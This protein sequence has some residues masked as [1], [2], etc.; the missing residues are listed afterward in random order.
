MGSGPDAWREGLQE[1]PNGPIPLVLVDQFGY[2]PQDPKFAVVRDPRTG[3]DVAVD[4][5]PGATYALVNAQTGASVKQGPLVPWNGGAVD[6]K[7]GD[8]LWTFDFSDVTTPGSYYV[9]DVER[10]KRS[11]GFEIAADVYRKLF[12]HVLRTFFYQRAGF[13]K[14]A[15]AAGADWADEASHLKAGQDAET[16]SWLDKTDASK[17]KDLHGGWYDA[18]DYNKYTS[19]HARYV[20][21]LLRTF[22]RYPKAF[23]DDFGIPESGNGT[24]DL[25]D[26]VKFGLDWLVR[27]QNQDGSVLCIQGL[28]DASPPSKATGPSYYGPATTS[29]TLASA[30]AFAY[31]ARIFAARTEPGFKELAAD[32]LA[33]AVKAWQFASENPAAIYYNNDETKQSGSQGLGA[34][35][36]EIEEPARLGW[37]VEA[38][39]YLFER[40]GEAVYRDFFD[41]NYLTTVPN[42]G[43]SHWEV[44]RHEAA[45]DYA[46]QSAAT[47]AVASAIL[48]QFTAQLNAPDGLARAALDNRDGY[49]SPVSEYTWGSNNSKAAVGRLLLLAS[50]YGVQ[51]ATAATTR[52]A[53]LDELHYLH[54]VNPLGLVYLSNMQSVGAEHSVKTFYHSWFSYKNTRWSEVTASAPGP[55]PGFLVGG[56]NPSYALDGCCSDGSKCSGSADFKF[57]SMEL[58]PPIGQPPAKSYRQFNLG[59]PADSWAVTENSNGYQVQYIR[60]L[61]AYIE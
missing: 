46:T 25:L 27:M 48:A 11:P 4:F 20:I 31:A 50:D 23:G 57:C 38:A 28:S 5:T 7:S 22:A 41:Q 49:R 29:A 19:W 56:P 34:G 54:G 58:T 61:A 53:A 6:P 59:W 1:G 32:Y 52:A 39:A 40:T 47:A 37:K 13:E 35:Q 2:R 8:A 10:A 33:R 43:L 14:T 16:R 60:V 18:G 51:A 3:Y 45:L 24:P 55:A 15:A 17:A 12:R 9:L 36:Q 26:E 21:T 30:A 42:Y 44:E